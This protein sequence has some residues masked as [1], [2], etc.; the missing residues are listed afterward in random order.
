MSF[1]KFRASQTSDWLFTTMEL[2]MIRVIQFF[3]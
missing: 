3:K 2:Y 1:L